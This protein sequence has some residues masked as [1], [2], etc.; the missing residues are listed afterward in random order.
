MV[1]L[2]AAAAFLPTSPGPGQRSGSASRL[3]GSSPRK[4]R[5]NGHR[6][7]GPLARTPWTGFSLVR[8]ATAVVIAQRPSRSAADPLTNN[9]PLCV[10]TA[11][12]ADYRG[13]STSPA[14][15][16]HH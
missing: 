6:T 11:S 14:F 3:V 13:L 10:K 8:L 15:K 7:I 9:H 12:I 5:L 1:E 4:P 2:F 16:E